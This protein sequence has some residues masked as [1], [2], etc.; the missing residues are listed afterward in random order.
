MSKEFGNLYLI[1]MYN[2]KSRC[3][4]PSQG[5]KKRPLCKPLGSLLV[6]M[7]TYQRSCLVHILSHF[8]R[9]F[10]GFSMTITRCGS[11][12]GRKTASSWNRIY[13]V[14]ILF[15]IEPS[16]SAFCKM[17]LPIMF[18]WYEKMTMKIIHKS[19]I[20][21]DFKNIF[22]NKTIILIIITKSIWLWL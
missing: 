10:G 22:P 15:V 1:P 14:Q 11:E 16:Y 19:D 4:I 20:V 18:C 12:D 3:H 17:R 8:R 6:T 7:D 13:A 5:Y 21:Y 2:F 9:T